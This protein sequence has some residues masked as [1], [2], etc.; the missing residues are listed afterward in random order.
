MPHPLQ[1]WRPLC[2]SNGVG[3]WLWGVNVAG[4]FP[5]RSQADKPHKQAWW[6]RSR[7]TAR[8]GAAQQHS[9]ACRPSALHSLSARKCASMCR[10]LQRRQGPPACSSADPPPPPN[11]GGA[12]GARKR[13][14]QT[15]HK[16]TNPL[17]PLS[18]TCLLAR[19]PVV[20]VGL[21]VVAVAA[22]PKPSPPLWPPKVACPPRWRSTSALMPMW[23]QSL[24]LLSRA[25]TQTALASLTTMRYVRATPHLRQQGL[26]PPGPWPRFGAR[27][28]F[29]EDHVC[30]PLPP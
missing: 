26:V 15:L 2:G 16:S 10:L 29:L 6:G 21:G 8:L 22:T 5:G 23:P 30:C 12:A 27:P 4:S 28:G 14:P 19:V 9:H 17:P 20:P 3:P 25:P 13:S 18:R 24:W 7:S 11:V 1:H